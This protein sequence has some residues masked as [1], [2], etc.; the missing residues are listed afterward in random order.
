MA[1]KHIYLPDNYVALLQKIKEEENLKSDSEV[2]K[3]VLDEYITENRIEKKIQSIF[4]NLLEEEK[5][6][7]F[8]TRT[9]FALASIEKYSYMNLNAMNTLL[10]DK[11][12]FHKGSLYSEE[13]NP[14]LTHFEEIYKEMISN[15]KQKKDNQGGF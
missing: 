3:F 6:K 7:N 15:N 9:R 10:N 14:S 13:P 4:L 1:R 5:I 12:I 11:Q 8:F 2:I